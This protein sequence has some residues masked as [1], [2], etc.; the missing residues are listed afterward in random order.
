MAKFKPLSGMQ[1]PMTSEGDIIIQTGG[2]PAR[3]AVGGANQVLTSQGGDPKWANIPTQLT[4]A[5]ETFGP[6]AFPADGTAIAMTTAHTPVV[7]LG[8]YSKVD[9]SG[10]V[11]NGSVTVV[12][13]SDSGA[14]FFGTPEQR[15]W[16]NAGPGVSMAPFGLAA[17][18]AVHITVRYL[19]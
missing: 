10:A 2:V 16:I 9:A 18:P 7:L 1:N 13:S 6:F 17:A 11:Y 19:W 14:G 3:L 15:F 8:G 4:L 5:E 12:K